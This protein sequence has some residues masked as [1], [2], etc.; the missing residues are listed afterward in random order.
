LIQNYEINTVEKSYI[1]GIKCY[2]DKKFRHQLSSG[3]I[4]ANSFWWDYPI[5]KN[6]KKQTKKTW[7]M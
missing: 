5:K 2:R 6:N 1:A 4:I 7:Y 3:C